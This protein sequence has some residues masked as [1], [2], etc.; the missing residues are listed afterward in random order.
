MT[1]EEIEKIV[2]ENGGVPEHL[3]LEEMYCFDMLDLLFQR[4]RQGTISKYEA[5]N[6]KNKI[7]IGFEQSKYN[8]DLYR[9]GH[10]EYQ[11]N[12]RKAE[13][14]RSDIIKGVKAEFGYD[15]LFV[16]AV[17]CIGKMTDDKT[18]KE[19]VTKYEKQTGEM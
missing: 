10:R 6:R 5:G 17:E 7:K 19:I 2:F 4:Y 1:F 11:E 3:M 15:K 12:I 14:L 13:S 16:L 8:R 18:F 9:D